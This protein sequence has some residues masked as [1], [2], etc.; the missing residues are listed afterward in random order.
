MFDVCVADW[1]YMPVCCPPCTCCCCCFHPANLGGVGH[2]QQCVGRVP[3][4]ADAVAA[5]Q[6]WVCYLGA[7]TLL[8]FPAVMLGH[9]WQGALVQVL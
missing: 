9:A 1:V 5:I 6:L 7:C 8:G 2:K 3:R 4:C